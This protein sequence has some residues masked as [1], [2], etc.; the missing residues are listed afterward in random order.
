MMEEVNQNIKYKQQKYFENADRP[1]KL[2]AW[3]L[4]ERRKKAI[5]AKLKIGGKETTQQNE[6]KN[7]FVKYYTNLYKRV[8][9]DKGLITNYINNTKL[10]K[11]MENT[12]EILNKDVEEEEVKEMKKGKTPGP[13]VFSL[14]FYKMLKDELCPIFRTLTTVIIETKKVPKKKHILC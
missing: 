13:D 10:P 6:I 7:G 4:K 1:G 3:Q 14:G 11:A 9:V 5:I 2:L 8:I 12:K